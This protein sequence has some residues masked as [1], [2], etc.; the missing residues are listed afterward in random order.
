MPATIL[1]SLMLWSA[2]LLP[3][4]KDDQTRDLSSSHS[5]TSFPVELTTIQACPLNESAPWTRSEANSEEEED[6]TDNDD[7]V[8]V[9][10]QCWTLSRSGLQGSSSKIRLDRGFACTPVRSTILRC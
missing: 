2:F 6:S 8:I 10:E 7:N 9:A 4:A 5:M 3:G 1:I